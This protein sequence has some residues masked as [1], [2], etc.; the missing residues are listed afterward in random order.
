MFQHALAYVIAVLA[1]DKNGEKGASAVEYAIL[2]AAIVALV[3]A[4]VALFGTDLKAKFDSIIP[5]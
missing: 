5:A 3:G 1:A 4:A 2:V